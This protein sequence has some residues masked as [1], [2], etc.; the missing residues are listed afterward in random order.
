MT[1]DTAELLD[2][3]HVDTWAAVC[4]HDGCGNRL[5]DRCTERCETCSDI[6][7]PNHQIWLD[8]NSRLFCPDH[9][10][11]YVARKGACP[12]IIP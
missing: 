11:G 10:T 1:G 3:G 8:D 9:S 12:K 5:C 7:C 2:C 6:L 4:Q